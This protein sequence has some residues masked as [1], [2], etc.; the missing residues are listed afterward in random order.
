MFVWCPVLLQNTALLKGASVCGCRTQKGT[1]TVCASYSLGEEIALVYMI[2]AGLGCAAEAF[3]WMSSC[4]Q[5]PPGYEGTV[6]PRLSPGLQ[7][8]SAAASASP[9]GAIHAPMFCQQI[10]GAVFVLS[11]LIWLV[12]QQCFTH[13]NLRVANS[14]I[15]SY[16]DAG[17][18]V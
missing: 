6:E 12:P 5:R 15:L 16:A 2:A 9:A 13:G 10:L 14:L 4:S 1:F 17:S 3:M 18:S 8:S 7:A 11:R